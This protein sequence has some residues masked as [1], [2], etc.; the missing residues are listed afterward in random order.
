MVRDNSYTCIATI[1]FSTRRTTLSLAEYFTFLTGGYCT[2]V[3]VRDLSYISNSMTAVEGLLF[4]SNTKR[5]V[6]HFEQWEKAYFTFLNSKRP[7]CILQM[8]FLTVGDLLFL[9]LNSLHK[10]C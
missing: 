8:T 7:T 6:L 2:F 1:F 10:S 5:P 4:I 3:I 9:L